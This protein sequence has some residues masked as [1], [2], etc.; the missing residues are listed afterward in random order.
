MDTAAASFHAMSADISKTQHTAV[1]NDNSTDTGSVKMI[2]T[3]KGVIAL[4]DIA[5][6]DPKAYEYEGRTVRI[7]Y[8]NMKQV[9]MYDVGKSGEQLAGQFFTLGFGTSGKDLEKNYEIQLVGPETLSG[10]N[11]THLTLTPKA[12]EAQKVIKQVDLWLSDANYPVQEKVLEPSG[13][14][15]LFVYKNVQINPSLTAQDVKLKLPNG[16]TKNN[17]NK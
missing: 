6:P 13:D 17:V 10:Q 1:L 14:Y 9:D 4:M 5:K 16:V 11:T 12:G 3:G 15:L 8:P 2:K 7:Y